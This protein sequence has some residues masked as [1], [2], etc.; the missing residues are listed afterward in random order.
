MLTDLQARKAQAR[1]KD[2]KLSDSGGLYLFVTAKG[3]KSWRLKYR[4]A[5]REKRLV[6]GQY[7]EISLSEARDLRD[8]ARRQVP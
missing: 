8:E 5:G 6:F 4:F 7:P 3:A 1:D 2:Y